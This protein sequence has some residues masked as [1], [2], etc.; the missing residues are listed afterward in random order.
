[1]SQ[2]HEKIMD[3]DMR[4]DVADMRNLQNRLGSLGGKANL[5]MSRAANRAASTAR[6]VMKRQAADVY[7]VSQKKVAD[8]IKIR[9]ATQSYPTASISARGYGIELYEFHVSPRRIAR[10]AKS[11]GGKGRKPPKFYSSRNKRRESRKPLSKDPK[12]F[13]AKRKNGKISVLQRVSADPRSEV[14]V[15]YGPSIPKM[16]ENEE[17]MSKVEEESTKMLLKRIEHEMD[18]VLKGGGSR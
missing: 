17:V 12:P 5:V 8:A 1:M 4:Y 6:T 13:V 15:K 11:D 2:R 3:F 16:L 14:W 18:R 7:I 10:P 9:K